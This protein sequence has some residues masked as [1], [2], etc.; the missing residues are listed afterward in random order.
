M[1]QRDFV[2]GG[3]VLDEDR[4][5]IPILDEH[6]NPQPATDTPFYHWFT[7]GGSRWLEA[8]PAWNNLSAGHEGTSWGEFYEANREDREMLPQ[9]GERPLRD[10]RGNTILDKD[11]DIILDYQSRRKAPAR[12]LTAAGFVGL[13]GRY[14]NNAPQCTGWMDLTEN[15]GSGS[16]YILWSEIY[17]PTTA[18]AIP[19]YTGKYSPEVQGN[20]RGFAFVTIGSGIEDFTAPAMLMEERLIETINT[21]LRGNIEQLLIT[22]IIVFTLIIMVV[23]L[24]ASTVTKRIKQL[25]AGIYRFRIG[26]RQFRMHSPSTDE[27]GMLAD[28]FDEMADSIE[29]SVKAP[30]VITDLDEKVIYMNTYAQDKVGRK[31]EEVVGVP[32]GEISMYPKGSNCDPVAALHE[33]REAEVYKA[34]SAFDT[35]DVQ[36]DENIHYYKGTANYCYDSDGIII[37][38]IIVTNDVTDIQV[39][40]QRAE[41]ASIAKSNFLSN[42]SHEIRTPLNAIIGMT[43][44]GRASKEKEKK[45]YSLGKIYDASKHLLGIINDILDVSKIEANKFSLSTARF[46]I[47]ELLERV[48]DVISLRVEQKQQILTVRIDDDMPEVLVGDDQR[49]MQVIMNL[50]SNA[51]KFTAEHGQINLDVKLERAQSDFCTLR[52]AVTDNGIGISEEQ[53]ER[54]FLPF[55]Q[56]EASTSRRFGGTGLG[57]VICKSIVEMMGGRI[58]VDSE[59]G[60]GATVAFTVRLAY[61]HSGKKSPLHKKNTGDN[62]L[63]IDDSVTE[64]KGSDFSGFSVLLAEDVEINREIVLALLEPTKLK[65]DCAENGSQAVDAFISN[66]A[67]YDMIF[68]DIQMPEMD[69]FTATKNIRSS[70]VERSTEVPIIAMTANAFKEDIDKCL[71]SGMNGHIGKPLD[72]KLVIETLEKYLRKS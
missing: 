50:L 69:G 52:V 36:K 71:E 70:G 17:K 37:G 22:S 53:Q 25:V 16:F 12:E 61:D 68:M 4:R 5:S 20:K 47:D 40:R 58:W 59:L 35:G 51:V 14:L 7:N 43:S 23:I 6:G 30:L 62:R 72:L 21:N 56:A 66:P 44:I 3:F 1:L 54:L 49:L 57:L 41:I 46:S 8:N 19:Y 67:K 65:I 39:A 31:L 29:N 63:S 64:A 27:F 45:D 11:G 34:A 48:V 60:E 2:E 24:V 10:L 42:M 32:Y 28:S 18:G 13:D 15:G 26:E 38:Y 9:F 55:E 33:G